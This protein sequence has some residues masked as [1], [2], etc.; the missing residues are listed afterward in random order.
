MA[1]KAEKNIPPK[2]LEAMIMS[3]AELKAGLGTLSAFGRIQ[4]ERTSSLR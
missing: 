3:G 1:L 4:P 2:A